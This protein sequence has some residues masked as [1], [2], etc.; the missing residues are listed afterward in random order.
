MIFV[1]IGTTDFNLLVEKM[2]TLVPTLPDQVVM[3]IGKST[4]I[5]K[6]CEYFRF[7]P[8]L[9]PYIDQADLVVSQGGMAVTYE[10]LRKNKKL[11]SVENTTYVDGHQKDILQ[12][13]EKEHYLIW[14]HDV[15]GLPPLLQN[16]QNIK[17]TPYVIPECTIAE[18][19]RDY[20]STLNKK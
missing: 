18:K 8:S 1:T 16:I 15:E 11:I 19:I 6:N 7:A 12:I 10:V 9:A 5:P 13:L 14:C 4:Y 2:D 20:L 17:L 3:Q